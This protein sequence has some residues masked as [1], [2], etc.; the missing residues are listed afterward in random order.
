MATAAVLTAIDQPL[1][2]C[3]DVEV[4][5]PRAGEVGVRMAAAGVC[6]SDLS[7]QDG[8]IATPLPVVLGH[9]GAGVVEE[10]GEGVE[11]LGPGDHVVLCWVPHCGRCFFCARGQANL[12]EAS[13]LSLGSMLL[14]GTTRLSR[15]GQPLFQMLAQGTFCERCV[16][17]ASAAVK[18]PD[19]V[20][21][22]VAAVLGC[23]V[24]TGVGAAVNTA[25]IAAGDA[26]AVVGCGGVGLNVV[27]GARLRGAAS[28]IAVDVNPAKLA[29]AAALGATATV[30]ARRDPVG[31]VMALTG[32]R[33]ADVAFEVVGLAATIE[34]T[35]QM[36]RR[37]GQ[38]VLVG[39]PRT[40]VMLSLPAFFGVVMAAKTI[41]GCWYGSSDVGR[42]IPRLLALYRDGRLDLD[43]LVSRTIPLEEVNDALEAMKQ[44]ELAR[45]VVLY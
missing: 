12:C 44:G 10:V 31:Q 18:I 37:G 24:L 39:V 6:H 45:T 1:E 16:V 27:Q 2:I 23:G 17:P 22:E 36:T 35:V 15:R 29:M 13:T 34:Q 43:A 40:D 28:I 8:T 30:D 7:M 3:R 4:A 26:V 19:D 9:E 20:P 32:Q 14:D 25:D 33:G 5:G 41:K 11:G 42:D 38:A 21:M